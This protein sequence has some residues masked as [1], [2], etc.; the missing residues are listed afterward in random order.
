VVSADDVDVCVIGVPKLLRP[1]SF[2]MLTEETPSAA[3]VTVNVC[4]LLKPDA[5]LS[6]E[7]LTDPALVAAGVTTTVDPSVPLG[8]TVN[9][10]GDPVVPEVEPDSVKAFATDPDTK[11]T[12]PDTAVDPVRVNLRRLVTL[13]RLK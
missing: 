5:K 8:V 3:R 2:V 7:G 10:V 1:P 12:S 13:K 6:V 4:E 11:S 9:V